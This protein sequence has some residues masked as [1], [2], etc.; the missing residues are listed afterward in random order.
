[1]Q[2]DQPDD[3]QSRR[4]P[5]ALAAEI[6]GILGESAIALNPGEVLER[7]PAGRKLS[8]SAVVTTL[9]RLHEKGVVTRE[10]NG[11]AFRYAAVSDPPTLVAW[12]MSRILDSEA[13]HAPVLSRF[14][15]ALSEQD[16][17]LLR[18]LLKPED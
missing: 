17:K 5:G 1:M 9:T 11:R 12:R 6:L 18:E 7:L 4:K 3:E 15:S 16:E 13:D 10:R 14:V 2:S 8:Y